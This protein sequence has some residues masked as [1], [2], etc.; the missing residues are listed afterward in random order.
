MSAEHDVSDVES[1][2]TLAA[3]GGFIV[4]AGHLE[5][6]ICRLIDWLEGSQR[7]GAI[8]EQTRRLRWSALA[9]RLE[10]VADARGIGTEVCD[11]LAE[12][13]LEQAM[14]FRHS[15]VH[16]Q[17]G[18]ADSD[19]HIVRRPLDGSADH[20]QIGSRD[21]ILAVANRMQELNRRLDL[22]MPEKF[23]RVSRNLVLG[24]VNLTDERDVAKGL[25][26]DADSDNG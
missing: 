1:C 9:Q 24:V 8:S 6:T 18:V 16:G 19:I 2:T 17:V 21:D 4:T 12:F 13:K 3:I 7:P 5:G 11:L 14:K 26:P 20:I 22:L 23:R 15:L 25:S 10:K